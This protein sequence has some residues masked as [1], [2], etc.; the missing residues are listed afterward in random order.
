MHPRERVRN[1][2]FL[3]LVLRHR[4]DLAGITLDAAGWVDVDELLAGCERAGR[5]ITRAQLEEIVATN[6]KK[7]FEFDDDHARI[8]ASQ[9]HSVEVDLGYEPADPPAILFHGTAERNLESIRR[10]GLLRGRRHHVHLSADEAT[11]AAVGRRYGTP[12]VLTVD[13]ARMAADGLA[14]FLSTNAVWLTAH[15]PPEYLDSDAANGAPE[16]E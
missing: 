7:R 3:S 16:P 5:A 13:A 11:A 15:V 14:F 9:G 1:S 10:H 2:K 12:V 4:P 6:D 8:R